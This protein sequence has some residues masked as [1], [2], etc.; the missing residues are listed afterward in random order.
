MHTHLYGLPSAFT[1]DD[2]QHGHTFYDFLKDI[3]LPASPVVGMFLSW[4]SP[5]RL[6]AFLVA[7]LFFG[8]IGAYPRL[9]IALGRRVERLRDNHVAEKEFPKFRQLVRRF[10]EFVDTRTSTTLHYI[11]GNDLCEP[12]RTE[13]LRRLGIPTIAFWSERWYFF[14][15]RLNRQ[16]PSLPELEFATSEFHSIVAEFNNFCV[17]PIFE[18]LPRELRAMLTEQDE[19]K[20]NGFQQRHMYFIADYES[21]AKALSESRP[22][23]QRLP[24]CFSHYNPL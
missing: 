16:I 24:S 6:W 2:G 11:I 20:L 3:V 23:L 17:A 12:L 19:S 7:A 5:W 4:N 10:G 9:K 13:L 22:V 15:V 8:T 14:L 21:F 18:T 1:E